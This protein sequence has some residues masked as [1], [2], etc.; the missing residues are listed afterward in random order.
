MP[1][2]KKLTKQEQVYINRRYPNL[3]SDKVIPLQVTHQIDSTSC[4]VYAGAFAMFLCLREDPCTQD[5]SIDSVE[6][7][8]HFLNMIK[9]KEITPFPLKNENVIKI[10]DD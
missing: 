2:Y 1:T 9:N 5:Y 7:R 10:L 4:E 3:N 8:Q 6:M